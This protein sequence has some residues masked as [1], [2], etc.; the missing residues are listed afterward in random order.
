M[1][2]TIFQSIARVWEKSPSEE[3]TEQEAEM[4]FNWVA[5]LGVWRRISAGWRR[6]FDEAIRLRGQAEAVY[7][8]D[9]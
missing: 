1:D 9:D 4:N 6:W 3:Q 5:M 8:V 2:V 7:F